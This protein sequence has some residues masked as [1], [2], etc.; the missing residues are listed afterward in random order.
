ML[1]S[2]KAERFESDLYAAMGDWLTFQKSQ[3]LRTE[4]RHLT[5]C[6]EL[7]FRS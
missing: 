7:E 4:I 3:I 1:A 6:G 5:S 2:G